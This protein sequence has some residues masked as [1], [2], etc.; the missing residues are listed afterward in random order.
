MVTPMNSTASVRKIFKRSVNNCI[1]HY[2]NLKYTCMSCF[3][4]TLQGGG[5]SRDVHDFHLRHA[6]SEQGLPGQG[7]AK[8][9]KQV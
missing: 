3:V 7:W 2:S 8:L 5:L 6:R 1:F 9:K 4:A